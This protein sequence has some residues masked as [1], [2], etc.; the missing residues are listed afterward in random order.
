MARKK[1]VVVTSNESY[2]PVNTINYRS[3]LLHVKLEEGSIEQGS[4]S[5]LVTGLSYLNNPDTGSKYCRAKG[6]FKYV[7][8]KGKTFTSNELVLS[9]DVMSHLEPHYVTE[10]Q[11]ER[12]SKN[13]LKVSVLKHSS[14]LD[15]MK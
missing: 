5:A 9:N 14:V 10:L 11:L 12:D 2:T 13:D 7:D 3:I 15:S 6:Y 8:G 4:L 1:P